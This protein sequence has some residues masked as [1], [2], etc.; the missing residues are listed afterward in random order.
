M[1]SVE[2]CHVRQV[3]P[4]LARLQIEA[5]IYITVEVCGLVVSSARVWGGKLTGFMGLV[6]VFDDAD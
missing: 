3:V 6:A 5:A 1:L 2:Y 4:P